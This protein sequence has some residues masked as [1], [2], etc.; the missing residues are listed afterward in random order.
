MSVG[1]T[2]HG[3]LFKVKHFIG[4]VELG[5]NKSQKLPTVQT[6]NN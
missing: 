4:P 5:T 1:L 2:W 3:Q 6:L